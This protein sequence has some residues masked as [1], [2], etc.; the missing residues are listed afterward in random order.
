MNSY[1]SYMVVITFHDENALKWESS[2]IYSNEPHLL[3]VYLGIKTGKRTVSIHIATTVKYID[4]K[5]EPR[6]LFSTRLYKAINCID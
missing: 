1:G 3:P 6:N 4:Y 5:I 2:F